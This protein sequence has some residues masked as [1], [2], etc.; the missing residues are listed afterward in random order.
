MLKGN[1]LLQKCQY[2]NSYGLH[3]QQR[4]HSW[5]VFAKTVAFILGASN[6]SRTTAQISAQK[7]TIKAVISK[8][9]VYQNSPTTKNRSSPSKRVLSC[10]SNPRARIA[11]HQWRWLCWEWYSRD[12]SCR[13]QSRTWNT[14]N[15][16]YR[17]C[18]DGF[19]EPDKFSFSF[20][21]KR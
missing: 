14:C 1:L 15:W 4:L 6:T 17:A 10:Y 12:H 20:F 21:F 5:N 18:L 13:D 3:L 16:Q 9:T 7:S 11:R 8:H 19:I 2:E